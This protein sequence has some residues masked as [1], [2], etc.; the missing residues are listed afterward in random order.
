MV[1]HFNTSQNAETNGKNIAGALV[2]VFKKGY[3]KFHVVGFSLGA[4]VS[5]FIGRNVKSLSNGQYEVPRI[6]GVDPGKLP[7]FST[8]QEL[9]QNDA[10]FVDTIHGETSDFGSAT[11]LGHANFWL[12]NGVKFPGCWLSVCSH[13]KTSLFY[14]DTV[15]YKNPQ[16][17]IAKKCNNY[18]EY[19]NN[20]CSG[21]TSP[22]GLYANESG[23]GN[24]YL[25]TN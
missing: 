1:F 11:A 16:L 10:K 24:Y 14:A 9:N 23:L 4:V 25:D 3:N 19:K 5:G 15:K 17:Y 21:E 2:E 6:T 13:I 8:I 12:N 22:V 18:A 20:Q 7:P